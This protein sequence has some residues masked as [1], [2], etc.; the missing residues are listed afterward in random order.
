MLHSLHVC[1]APH[2]NTL[3]RPSHFI[4]CDSTMPAGI[5]SASVEGSRRCAAPKLR[6]EAAVNAALQGGAVAA[7]LEMPGNDAPRRRMKK[8]QL[9]APCAHSGKV[10]HRR[11]PRTSQ[12]FFGPPP[13]LALAVPTSLCIDR[14]HP[15]TSAHLPW[16]GRRS[17]AAEER[18]HPV[19]SA[20]RHGARPERGAPR[21]NELPR[22]R[23][24]GHRDQ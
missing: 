5:N 9:S 10:W 17:T 18:Q 7:L 2:F 24:L 15:T 14:N 12:E 13:C 20:P 11:R 22:A 21:A 19:T 16:A 3:T 1:G 4:Q 23:G 6:G 8:Q